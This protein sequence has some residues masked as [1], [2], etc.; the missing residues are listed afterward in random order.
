MDDTFLCSCGATVSRHNT[1]DLIHHV[2]SRE[3]EQGKAARGLVDHNHSER[4]VTQDG[5][6]VH[7]GTQDARPYLTVHCP[8]CI[9]QATRVAEFIH[10]SELPDDLC[11]Y[12]DCEDHARSPWSILR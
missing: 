10:D 1:L 9:D 5:R 4:W 11:P 8:A 7:A 3:H 12:A 2:S 6:P